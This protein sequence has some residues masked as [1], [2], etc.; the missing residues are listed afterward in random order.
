MESRTPSRRPPRRGRPVR[1]AIRPPTPC[2][3]PSTVCTSVASIHS[4]WRS[5]AVSAAQTRSGGASTSIRSTSSGT[6][7]LLAVLPR[8]VRR[9]GALLH[10][11][12]DLRLVGLGRMRRKAFAQLG[13]DRVAVVEGLRELVE[14][15]VD[16]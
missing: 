12:L 15:P 4:P 9:P 2:A 1:A 6:G 3:G 10:V 7:Q 11:R 8:D 16:L 13:D 5:Q 14:Q